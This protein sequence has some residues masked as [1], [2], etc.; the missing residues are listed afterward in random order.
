MLKRKDY[1]DFDLDLLT[2]I[3]SSSVDFYYLRNDSASFQVQT[4][5]SVRISTSQT[6]RERLLSQCYHRNFGPKISLRSLFR[7]V[8][9]ANSTIMTATIGGEIA[10][11]PSL[12][13]SS[14]SSSLR[15]ISPLPGSKKFKLGGYEFYNSIG[16]P[17]YVVAPMVDQ[18]EL[19]RQ[20]TF[21]GSQ[22][23]N[24]TISSWSK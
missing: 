16:S 12:S 3:F 14:S 11:P 17:K 6:W 22:S 4:S 13:L 1:L 8:T 24:H 5:G 18:S 19:V 9:R 20:P 7:G 23:I 2:T 10:A 21:L 15:T